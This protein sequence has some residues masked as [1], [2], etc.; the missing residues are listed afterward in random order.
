MSDAV[1]SIREAGARPP[2]ERLDARLRIVA[3]VA[4]VLTLLALRSP[5]LLAGMLVAGIASAFAA[6]VGGRDLWHRL[7]HVEGFVAVLALLLPLTVPGPTAFALGPVALSLTGIERAVIALLRLNGAA[8]V[9]FVLLAG[10]EPARFGRALARLGLPEKLV[11]LL[12]FTTRWIGLVR[13][14]AGRLDEAMRVRGFRP[15][16]SRHGFLTLA[17]FVGQ[18]L[19][20]AFERAERVEEAMRCRGFSGRFAV[21]GTERFGRTDALFAAAL[22]FGLAAVLLVDRLT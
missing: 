20:R 13:A 1:L 22:G 2:L 15:R 5:P 21:V 11:H 14:E 18:L 19:V 12:L 8:I 10:I 17:R 16:T 9:V 4:V 3:A 6:G 7:A